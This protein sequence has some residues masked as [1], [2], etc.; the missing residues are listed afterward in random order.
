LI[1]GK[2]FHLTPL[3]IGLGLVGG[4]KNMGEINSVIFFIHDIGLWLGIILEV[5]SGDLKIQ[6]LQHL[7]FYQEKIGIILLQFE[8]IL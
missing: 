4:V 3:Q 8:R 2:H 7:I 1:E 6:E 5:L